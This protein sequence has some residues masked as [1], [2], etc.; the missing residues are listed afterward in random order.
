[1]RVIKTGILGIL[2]VVLAVMTGPANSQVTHQGLFFPE[3]NCWI[4]GLFLEYY[5]NAP[6]PERLFGYPITNEV[7]DQSTGLHSQ[8]FERARLDLLA[9]GGTQV[10]VAAPLGRL[11]YQPGSPQLEMETNT[12]ACRRVE[13]A[14][15]IF[16]V[17]HAFLDFYTRH[18]GE[19]FLG[20]PISNVE[21]E[22]GRFVQYFE[23]ARL[24]WQPDNASGA[25][26][27][28]SDLGRM[29][30]DI[31]R[32]ATLPAGDDLPI[33]QVLPQT[34]VFPA[35]ALLVANSTQTVFI[36]VQ[37]R[38]FNPLA[39]AVVTVTV[40]LPDGQEMVYRPAL[41]N[42]EGISHVEFRV[43]NHPGN[44]VVYVDVQ[45]NYQGVESSGA[46]W[47]RIW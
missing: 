32:P 41:T 5:Q 1:M 46:T 11:L 39:G 16:F 18:N 38:Q 34:H 27:W 47:F 9:V 30:Y 22:G 20:A 31:R 14:D 25:V 15:G 29:Y 24:E 8:Y 35:R 12:P 28:V 10:V 44:S 17:C 7:V 26:A 19:V 6:E 43:G 4:N 13:T 40:H 42:N 45:T 36:I 33:P 3:T 21:V 2:V 23:K 37:D